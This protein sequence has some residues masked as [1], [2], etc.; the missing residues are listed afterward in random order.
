MYRILCRKGKRRDERRNEK[1]RGR[2]AI[3]IE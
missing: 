2:P 1:V 3:V